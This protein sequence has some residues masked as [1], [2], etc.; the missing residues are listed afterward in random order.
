MFDKRGEERGESAGLV[1]VIKLD[2]ACCKE[3]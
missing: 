3:A 1:A 2:K